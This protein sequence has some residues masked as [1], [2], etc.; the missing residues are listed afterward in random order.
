MFAT[1]PACPK[2]WLQGLQTLIQCSNYENTRKYKNTRKKTEQNVAL[3]KEFLTLIEERVKTHE[4]AECILL[5]IYHYSS[6][7]RQKRRL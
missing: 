7:E 3:L 2:S 5:L 1:F 6:K 4:G